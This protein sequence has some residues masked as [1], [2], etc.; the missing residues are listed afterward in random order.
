MVGHWEPCSLPV[1]RSA[2]RIVAS[3]LNELLEGQLCADAVAPLFPGNVAAEDEP[4]LKYGP[5]LARVRSRLA[6]DIACRAARCMYH[7]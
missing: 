4:E 6:K 3:K 1:F 2:G 7:R 5:E